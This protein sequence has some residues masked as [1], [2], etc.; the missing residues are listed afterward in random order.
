MFLVTRR[1]LELARDRICRDA[2]AR[3]G[4]WVDLHGPEYQYYSPSDLPAN[5]AQ[6]FVRGRVP[7]PRFRDFRLVIRGVA[8]QFEDTIAPQNVSPR[9]DSGDPALTTAFARLEL[10]NR[11]HVHPDVLDSIMPSS[12]E[13]P[14]HS[15]V[16]MFQET[17]PSSFKWL[18]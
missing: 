2:R 8:A 10:V 15:F 5:F 12:L 4:Y 3:N 7:F 17:S 13:T 16:G 6:R 9:S 11:A 1:G 14:H 18:G